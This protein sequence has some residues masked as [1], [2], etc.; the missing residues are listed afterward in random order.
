MRSNPD[1]GPSFIQRARREQIIRAT[2]ETVAETG[3]ERA[4]LAR[5]AG[6][7]GIAKGS[8][9]Y[10]FEGRDQLVAAA[11][12]DVYARIAA[13]VTERLSD[14]AS[15]RDAVRRYITALVDH[16][17]AHRS[18]ARLISDAFGRVGGPDDASSQVE[19]RWRALADLV[20]AALAQR[21]A[22]DSPA[23]DAEVLAI[24]VSGAVDALVGQAL[25]DPSF[26]LSGAGETL[27]GYVDQLLDPGAVAGTTGT[28]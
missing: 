22:G 4:S 19:S 8:I 2:V 28:P 10:H 18:E 14:A 13:A 15:P 26:D 5:I 23:P 24:S 27:A 21:P 6:R 7:L 17:D 20:R 1:A 9:V 12:D 3:L 11:L 25:R 16:L